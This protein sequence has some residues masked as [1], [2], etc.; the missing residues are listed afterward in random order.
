M[1]NVFRD[2]QGINFLDYLEKDKTVTGAHWVLL[3]DQLKTELEQ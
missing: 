1:A 3:L 2:C